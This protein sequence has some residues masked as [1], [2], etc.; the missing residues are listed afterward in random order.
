MD[1]SLEKFKEDTEKF[2]NAMQMRD[3][4]AGQ[5][6][7]LSELIDDLTVKKEL[8]LFQVNDWGE[9]VKLHQQNLRENR[10]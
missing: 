9:Q 2:Y 1:A 7:L 10:G 4:W 8:A 5:T 3:Y 6:A